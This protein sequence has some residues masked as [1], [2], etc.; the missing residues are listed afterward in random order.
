M[1]GS[2]DSTSGGKTTSRSASKVAKLIKQYDLVGL[3]E[4]LEER[5]T[6]EEDR[7]SLRALAEYFNTELLAAV[8]ARNTTNVLDGEA[9]NYYE[10][11]TDDDIS[12]GT[13]IKTENK[14]KQYGIDV[15]QLRSEFVSRQA[16]H[17]YLTKER[18][19][20]YTHDNQT[21][22]ERV[23]A[24]INTIRRIKNRLVAVSEKIL[25][26]LTQSD[27]V[28]GGP[29]RVTVLVQVTCER[30]GIQY[31]IAEFI[32]NGGCDCEEDRK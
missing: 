10:L 21:D 9:E 16:I 20:S 31:P 23:S 25:S 30:C 17:T 32:S 14:L 13:R 18:N 22:D 28:S 5:W 12:S 29:T 19:T 24:R 1:T 3:G 4:E 15:E 7:M 6:R 27:Y 26:E 8:L 2:N 11:L